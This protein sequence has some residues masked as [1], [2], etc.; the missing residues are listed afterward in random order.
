MLVLIVNLHALENLTNCLIAKNSDSS[1]AMELRETS[2][3]Q[4]FYCRITTDMV[5]HLALKSLV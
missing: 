4:S 5:C 3:H 1:G 2:P